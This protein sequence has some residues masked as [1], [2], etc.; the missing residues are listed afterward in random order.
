MEQPQL[1]SNSS[2]LAKTHPVSKISMSNTSRD[3]S[4][5]I[6]NPSENAIDHFNVEEVPPK[7]ML[8]DPKA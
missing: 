4:M 1:Q 3:H 6:D 2:S 8:I 5:H 7:M